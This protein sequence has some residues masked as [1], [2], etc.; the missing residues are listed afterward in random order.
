[1]NKNGRRKTN[2]NRNRKTNSDT[3]TNTNANAENEK[4]HEK[5]RE[6]REKETNNK[7][8][9]NDNDFDS[10]DFGQKS[11]N[12]KKNSCE[13]EKKRRK[14]K[15]R[16]KKKKSK[17]SI[18]VS[19]NNVNNERND[20]NLVNGWFCQNCTYLN[21]YDCEICLMCYEPYYNLNENSGNKMN[22][23]DMF[24]FDYGSFEMRR[25]ETGSGSNF[26]KESSYNSDEFDIYS[27]NF[28]LFE[29]NGSTRYPKSYRKYLNKEKKRYNERQREKRLQT[30]M[31]KSKS[32]DATNTTE[33]LA[34]S[35][36]VF[37]SSMRN[38]IKKLIG[39]SVNIG[40]LAIEYWDKIVRIKCRTFDDSKFCFCLLV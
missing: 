5:R 25:N 37:D 36:Y 1:M 18:N 40:K 21:S 30:K 20:E 22:S 24:G 11:R 32:K 19:E 29:S 14:A 39:S 17:G 9:T 13:S 27:Y 3:N 26:N 33:F 38:E 6:E 10:I 7:N 8:D 16:R 34:R 28:D 2:K 35:S 4:K 31:K 12:E 15:S 23:N